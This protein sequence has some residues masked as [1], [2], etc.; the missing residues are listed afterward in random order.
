MAVAVNSK[1][2]FPK[3]LPHGGTR[4]TTHWTVQSLNICSRLPK[5]WLKLLYLVCL[6]GYRTV[7]KYK[8]WP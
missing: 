2:I 5:H 8:A 6:L 4:V 3:E 1:V 7:K